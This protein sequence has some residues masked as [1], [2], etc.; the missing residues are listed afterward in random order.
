MLRFWW[1]V[2]EIVSVDEVEAEA[3]LPWWGVL[4]LA[5]AF[6]AMGVALVVWPVL[7]ALLVAAG[8]IA[9]GLLLLPAAVRGGWETWRH[10][11]RRIRVRVA[12]S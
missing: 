4:G 11:P 7:L 10:R 2:P 12:R 9:A 6:I 8:L 1:L 3:S 5:I